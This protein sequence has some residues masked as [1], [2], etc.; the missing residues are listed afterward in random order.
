[1]GVSH[2]GH[3]HSSL[4]ALS[5]RLFFAFGF[6]D[7]SLAADVAAAAAAAAAVVGNVDVGVG[8][9]VAA[10]ISVWLARVLG[11]ESFRV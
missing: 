9:G 1:M 8:V 3:A 5:P 11:L 2:P 6:Q 7:G 4:S 10:M